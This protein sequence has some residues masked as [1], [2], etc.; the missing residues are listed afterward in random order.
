VLIGILAAIIG[1]LFVGGALALG[2]FRRSRA[3]II[4][5]RPETRVTNLERARRAK[6]PPRSPQPSDLVR[7]A[8]PQW[9]KPDDDPGPKAA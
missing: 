2:S 9:K 4:E 6:Q 3:Q 8:V 5:L 7:V 1:A